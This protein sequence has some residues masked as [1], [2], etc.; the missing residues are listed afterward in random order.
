MFCCALQFSPVNDPSETLGCHNSLNRSRAVVELYKQDESAN[1]NSGVINS[2]HCHYSRLGN[3]VRQISSF[4]RSTSVGVG[5]RGAHKKLAD[6]LPSQTQHPSHPRCLCLPL[7]V[8]LSQAAL[9]LRPSIASGLPPQLH[10]HRESF[11]NP[12][13]DSLPA[14]LFP[15]IHRQ[16]MEVE[17]EKCVCSSFFCQ[18]QK[19]KQMPT[20][21]EAEGE[22]CRKLITWVQHCQSPLQ[23]VQ[24]SP[25]TSYPGQLVASLLILN[26]LWALTPGCS[27]DVKLALLRFLRDFCPILIRNW[28]FINLFWHI[29]YS[30]CQPLTC[31]KMCQLCLYFKLHVAHLVHNSADT[32]FRGLCIW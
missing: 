2:H 8:S 6:P 28:I 23:Q 29:C 19:H 13:P 25:L 21:V 24:P 9:F 18:M 14:C 3:N 10:C 32:V 17:S 11:E 30:K 15:G 31:I 20:G 12:F 16:D 7:T 27:S 5:G 1:H 4:F 22:R 26:S